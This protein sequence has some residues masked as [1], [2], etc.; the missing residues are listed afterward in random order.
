MSKEDGVQV[1]CP[2]KFEGHLDF[3]AILESNFVLFIHIINTWTT[4][5]RMISWGVRIKQFA[6]ELD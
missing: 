6:R 1:P 5:Y 2:L 4:I 3:V